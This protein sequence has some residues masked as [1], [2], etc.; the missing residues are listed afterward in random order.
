LNAVLAAGFFAVH[1]VTAMAAQ[2]LTQKGQE[3]LL[4]SE[5]VQ[6]EIMENYLQLRSLGN[7]GISTHLMDC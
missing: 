4:R 3:Y 1:F 6:W 5:V 2:A 7:N